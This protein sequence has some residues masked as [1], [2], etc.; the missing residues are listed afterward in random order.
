[1]NIRAIKKRAKQQLKGNWKVA[2]L[3]LIIIS[4]LTG[5][6]SQAIFSVIGAGSFLS[7]PDMI[8]TSTYETNVAV[9]LSPGIGLLTGLVSFLIGLLSGLLNVGY[10]WSILDMVD[11]AK[12]TVESM[13]Q[14]F[15]KKRIWKILGLILVMNILIVLWSLL[16]IIPGIIKTY[17]YSQALNILKDDP[18]ISI[19]DAL[20]QSR[21]LMKG[22]KWKLF[23]LQLSIYLWLVVPLI[24]FVVFLLGSLRSLNESSLNDGGLVWV[25]V[26]LFL[27]L[28]LYTIAISFYIRP[29]QTTAAQ[30]FY[31]DLTDGPSQL[32][33]E[34]L[35]AANEEY[36]ANKVYDEEYEGDQLDESEF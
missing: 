28:L 3:N 32:N 6:M 33:E 35:N 12:L 36:A 14:T 30:V 24:V 17:S 34:S 1:M 27:G 11:G 10:N 25:F 5:I 13:F 18:D 15:R 20:D 7:L 4:V 23:I 2:I 9:T 31:R 26:L 21:Q 29:Y 16:L 8:S 22:K 19:M